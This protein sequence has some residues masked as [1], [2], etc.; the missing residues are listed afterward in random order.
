MPRAF[1]LWK[2]GEKFLQ[3][4]EGTKKTTNFRFLQSLDGRLEKRLDEKENR[5]LAV[6]M[7]AELTIMKERL[8]TM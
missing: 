7:T 4:H 5:D 3:P 8:G 6:S 1:F 2:E